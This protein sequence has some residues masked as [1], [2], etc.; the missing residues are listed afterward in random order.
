MRFV[1]LS[2][3]DAP[4]SRFGG[5]GA[6]LRGLVRDGLPVPPFAAVMAEACDASMALAAVDFTTRSAL[7]GGDA[8]AR[9]RVIAHLQ[10][11]PQVVEEILRAVAAI[12]PDGGQLAVRSSAMDEDGGS[13]SFAGQLDSV[14]AVAPA[15][16]PAAVARVWRSAWSERG[17][18]Y[19][20][21]RGLGLPRPPAVLIQRMVDADAAGVA[22]A[23][24][25]VEGRWDTAVVSAV[26]GLGTALVG[27]EAD[28]DTWHVDRAG[29]ILTAAIAAKTVAH[30]A[31]PG[32][33]EGVAP[34]TVTPEQ[35]VRPVLDDAQ[36]AAVAALAR[37]CSHLRGRPQDIEWALAG[38]ELWLLQSRP[39]T[40]LGQVAD[41]AGMPALWDDSNIAESYNGITTPLTYSFARRAYEE[42]YRGFC[43]LM[44]VRESVIADHH[45]TFRAMIGL[46]RGRVYYDLLNWYRVLA[47]LPGYAFNRPFMEQMMGVKEGLPTD[48]LPPPPPPSLFAR[49][50][51]GLR[52][53]RTVAALG[54]NHLTLGRQMRRFRRRLDEALAMPVVD[55]ADQRP[56]ELAAAYR[57]LEH[58]LL[59][60]WDAPLVNDFLAMIFFGV[61][62]TRCARWCGDD[63]GTLQ[64]DLVGGEGGLVS[65]EPAARVRELA[66]LVSGS[67]SFA[68][69]LR[70]GTAAAIRVAMRERQAFSDGVAA[71]LDRFGDRCL[72]ELKLE[73]PTLVDDPLPLWRAIGH[74][75]A[76][77]AAPVDHAAN[78]RADAEARVTAALT[79]HPIR[80]RL[81]AWVLRN[82]RARVRDREN[83]RFERTRL[84][85][86]VRRI[87]V[88]LGRRLT[89]VGALDDARDVFWLEVEEVLGFVQGTTTCDDLRGLVSVRRAAF[90]R[91]RTQPPPAD[92]FITRGSVWTGNPFTA[93]TPAAPD[94]GGD[95]RRGTGCCPGQV[96][97]LV[98]VVRDPRG[99]ELPAGTVLVAERT[100]PGWIMLFPACAG[101][102]VERGSLLS[103]SAIVAR[104][105][106]I[107]AIVAVPG[108]TTWLRDGD[109]VAFDGASGVVR[110]VQ[111]ASDAE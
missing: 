17:I 7:A 58:R 94:A 6:A 68:A 49:L 29:A 74:F 10:P 105:L 1:L 69:L 42:V 72:E 59:T 9:Q 13:S 88:E 90:E 100:D 22:F 79:G 32:T 47:L 98:R 87:L 65:A 99:V 40:T 80:R 111:R 109:T 104:E 66:A 39:I 11:A 63:D 46:I 92:R 101:L 91:Y 57:D 95:E 8:A 56:D 82:A 97:G 30:R 108:I 81:F 85:G 107:P 53:L 35:A 106:G 28:A 78:A 54:W 71:Y 86:R 70:T 31:A 102:L 19:R 110:L 44:G 77:P 96:Q 84:F 23:V 38:D 43:R 60:R 24:D 45:A 103:H 5:K 15:D 55:L 51:D 62:R 20:R 27:G 64:N 21:S 75:A 50:G 12:A 52:L 61:L 2:S 3:D 33:A 25:P 14:L 89:A 93:A 18:A 67:E 76:R 16:V 48:L 37:R 83:L 26:W 4:D 36:V 41:P 73:S 34:V